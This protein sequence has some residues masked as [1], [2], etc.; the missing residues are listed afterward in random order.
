M[1]ALIDSDQ[2]MNQEL[3][4][5]FSTKFS[6][7]RREAEC[8]YLLAYGGSMKAMAQILKLSPRTIEM[9][10]AKIK[11]KTGITYKS[12]LTRK[13]VELLLLSLE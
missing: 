6:F 3:H 4:H 8:F 10:I 12:E 13:A 1:K 11:Q 2:I 9:Y 7:T 5:L